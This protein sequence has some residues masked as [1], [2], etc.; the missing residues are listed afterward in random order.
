MFSFTMVN[1]PHDPLSSIISLSSRTR[2][3]DFQMCKPK[4]Y[5]PC[6]GFRTG[7]R[8]AL[9]ELYFSLGGALGGFYAVW[10]YKLVIFTSHPRCIM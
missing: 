6:G 4:A 8:H 3:R 7:G 1:I 9:E 2:K 5:H 10:F